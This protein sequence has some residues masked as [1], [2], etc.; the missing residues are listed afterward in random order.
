MR[1]RY[2]AVLCDLF[3]TLVDDRGTA[4]EGAG[5]LLGRLPQGRWAIVTSCG[6]QFAKALLQ[7]AGLPVPSV[8]VSADDVMQTKP[9]PACY[10]R[11]AERLGI[12]PWECLVIEDSASGV[13]AGKSAGMDVVAIVR[14]NRTLDGADRSVSALAALQLVAAKDGTIVLADR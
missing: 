2:R 1:T 4:I 8:L 3:G 5:A 13:R 10:L 11:A 6:S 9:S 14:G 7:R 12:R